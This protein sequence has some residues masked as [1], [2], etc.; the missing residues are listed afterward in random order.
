LQAH[1]VMLLRRYPPDFSGAGLQAERLAGALVRQGIRVSVLTAAASDLPAPASGT[2]AGVHVRRFRASGG[3][4][5]V[6]RALGLRS[7][8]W[9]LQNPFDVLHL[10]GFSAF[11]V[12]PV[13]VA[14]L[15]GRPVLVKTT[16][17]QDRTEFDRGR[18]WV[19][20]VLRAVG[21]R[22]DAV[23]ALSDPIARALE[24]RGIDAN[25]IVTLPNGV[26]TESLRPRTP[27][28]RNR[29]RAGL[30]L[31]PDAFVVVTVGMLNRRK[32]QLALVEAAGRMA[33]R[34]L[35][36]ALVGPPGRDPEDAA[37]LER[38]LGALP[39]EVGVS[40]PGSVE[41]ERLAE[42]LGAADAFTL[43]SRAE[44]MPNALLEAMAA[45]LPCVATDVAGS[46]DVLARHGGGLLVALDDVQA[47]AAA[48]DGLAAEPGRR[49]RLGAEARAVVERG[50]SLEAV[51]RR[52]V[53]LYRRLR[54]RAA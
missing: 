35:H 2:V 11:A 28:E 53:E 50:F 43:T 21:R 29:L 1:V 27:A 17:L 14:W 30:G 25:R 22:I 12:P 48:L 34:P 24:D 45:G 32:N 47:L 10:H 18:G 38:A 16:L 20:T 31:P 36:L 3:R 19:P 9:L 6:E 7:A 37:P 26:D 42:W 23:V 39:P 33:T 15:R 44:G 40:R 13:T 51:A 8:R 5:A 54:R 52:Y 4:T 46:H 41:P 49:E